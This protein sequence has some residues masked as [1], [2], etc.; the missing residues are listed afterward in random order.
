[1]AP[2]GT[3]RHAISPRAAP[4]GTGQWATRAATPEADQ[5]VASPW[6]RGIHGRRRARRSPPAAAKEHLRV[7][8]FDEEGEFL[9][10]DE[11]KEDEEV[12]RLMEHT[13]EAKKLFLVSPAYRLKPLSL[14]F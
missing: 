5:G 14:I 9:E 11:L 3:D 2:R 1:M 6:T 10:F 12:I 4:R 8:S 13:I 7:G